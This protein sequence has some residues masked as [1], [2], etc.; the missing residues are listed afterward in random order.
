MQLS[1]GLSVALLA[2]L[3]I[4]GMR[5]ILVKI[6]IIVLVVLVVSR[7]HSIHGGSDTMRLRII[8][9][10]RGNEVVILEGM[11]AGRAAFFQL[12]TG[13]AGPPVLSTT[14]LSL[15]DDR[16]RK[17]GSG[18]VMHRYHATISAIQTRA[19]EQQRHGALSNFLRN[20]ECFSYTS[21]CTMKLM[22]IGSIVEQQADMLL[23]DAIRFIDTNG[24]MVTPLKNRTRY[25]RGDVFVTNPLPGSV[26][27][28][29]F[30]YIVHLM[31]VVLNMGA[32]SL[33]CNLDVVALASMMTLFRWSAPLRLS[34]GAPVVDIIIGNETFACTMDTGAPGPI[35]LGK[36][37]LSRLRGCHNRQ[38]RIQQGGVNG[39]KI[40]STVVESDVRFFDLDVPKSLIFVN[41]SAVDHTDG[42]VG[43][44]FLRAFDFLF[45]RSSI[46]VRRSGLLPKGAGDYPTSPG[47]CSD[48]QG[49]CA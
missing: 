38:E 35:C 23:C 19:T 7:V 41:D 24:R 13:Y 4:R 20:G 33:R 47:T 12:D 29:T 2:A 42:Y 34:G 48:M 15:D 44:G 45:T 6:I 16:H 25:D 49:V 30:D 11:I 8:D 22:G 31:P 27:I 5:A 36:Q 14:Y 43:M 1:A 17:I 32:S 37:A 46:H 40:C 28:L 21:G 3:L 26:H 18:D 9:D 10:S 39:E